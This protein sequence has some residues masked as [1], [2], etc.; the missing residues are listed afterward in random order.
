[1]RGRRGG[2]ERGGDGPSRDE[3]AGARAAGGVSGVDD[4]ALAR[5]MY[6]SDASLYRVPPRSWSTPR[7]RTAAGGAGGVPEFGAP[8]TMRGGGTSIAGNAVGPGSSWT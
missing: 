4:S 2:R 8:L 1:M 5:S 3:L 7:R 6:S